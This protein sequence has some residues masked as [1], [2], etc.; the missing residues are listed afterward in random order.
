MLLQKEL[1]LLLRNR[2]VRP[3]GR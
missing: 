2:T 3:R 1:S